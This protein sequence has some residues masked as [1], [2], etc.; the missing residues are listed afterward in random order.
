MM[1]T[2]QPIK[3]IVDKTNQPL[4]EIYQPLIFFINGML[5]MFGW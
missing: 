5:L 2:T 3:S 1:R 4:M